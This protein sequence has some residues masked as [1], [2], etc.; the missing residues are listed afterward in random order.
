[1]VLKEIQNKYKKEQTALF[2]YGNKKPHE[3]EALLF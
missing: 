1:M 2:F 3:K